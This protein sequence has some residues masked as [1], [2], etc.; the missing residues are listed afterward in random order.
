M[1]RLVDGV[2]EKGLEQGVLKLSLK[3]FTR[4][5][6]RKDV[7]GKRYSM[8]KSIRARGCADVWES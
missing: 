1:E 8:C 5:V 7:P 4:K 3:E 2:R 6:T